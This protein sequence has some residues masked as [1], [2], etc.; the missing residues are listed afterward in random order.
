MPAAGVLDR[1]AADEAPDVLVET[2]E[3]LLHR[4]DRAGVGHGGGNLQPVADD[5]GIGEQLGLPASIVASDLGGIEV[6]ER[7]AV[8]VAFAEDGVPAQARLRT[9]QDQEFEQA[10]IVVQR[11]APFVVVIGN[12]Q[13]IRRPTA[14]NE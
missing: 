13:W 14:A 10:P 3:L 6:V 2:A 1:P 12:G 4:Q 9:F 7:Q 11:H 5:A 8:G